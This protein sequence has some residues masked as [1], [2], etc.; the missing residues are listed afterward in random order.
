[1]TGDIGS[2]ILSVKY[3]SA[4]EGL[5]YFSNNQ[6]IITLEFQD[7][8]K[9][10]DEFKVYLYSLIFHPNDQHNHPNNDLDKGITW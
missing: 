1:M 4:V 10:H 9:L 8:C 2:L 6:T 5:K 7:V 3:P